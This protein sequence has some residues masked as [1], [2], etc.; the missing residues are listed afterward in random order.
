[1]IRTKQ[2]K[3]VLKKSEQQHL[4]ECG[5]NSMSAMERQVE[6]MKEEKATCLDCVFIAKKLGFKINVA[7]TQAA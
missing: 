7:D 3:K 6:F 4:T 1:M 5:I 2:A